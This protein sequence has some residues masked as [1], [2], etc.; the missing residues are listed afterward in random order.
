[1]TFKRFLFLVVIFA[2]SIKV[3]SQ[4]HLAVDLEHGVYKIIDSAE[5]KGIA[6]KVS[7]VRPFTR[8]QIRTILNEISAKRYQLTKHE[9][10]ILEFYIKE[11]KDAFD[12][13]ST[14]EQ[15]ANKGHYDFEGHQSTASIGLTTGFTSKTAVENPGDYYFSAPVEVYLKGDIYNSMFSY[16]L[17][18]AVSFDHLNKYPYSHPGEWNDV[19]MGFHQSPSD[20]MA[21]N[22]QD[23]M[24]I[25]YE[26][27][28]EFTGSFWDDRI[29]LR[30]GRIDD[31]NVGMG[32]SGLAVGKNATEYMAFEFSMRPVKSVNFYSMVASLS[33]DETDWHNE[34]NSPETSQDS[35]HNNKMMSYHVGEFF[36]SDYFYLNLWEEVIWGERFEFGYLNPFGVY[37]LTQNSEGDQD[38]MSMGIS[39][40][41]IAPKV[42]KVYY[43]LM[44]D[45][46]VFDMNSPRSQFANMAGVKINIP[47]LPFTTLN[48]QYTKIEPYVY[49]H[50]PQ[51]YEGNG[52]EKDGDTFWTDTGSTNQGKS[53]GSYLKPNSDEFILRL[54]SSPYPGLQTFIGWR[55]I[56][57]GSNPKVR[58]YTDSNGKTKVYDPANPPEDGGY[59]DQN[60]N[61]EFDNGDVYWGW[62][63]KKVNGELDAPLNYAYADDFT[64]DF[65]DDGIYD[66]TN[67]VGIGIAYDFRA[68][69]FGKERGQFVPLKISFEYQISYTFFDMNDINLTANMMAPDDVNDY[70][71]Y[72]KN[73]FTI[74]VT[75]FPEG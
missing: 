48:F 29:M 24:A 18:F 37:M 7:Q 64:K 67:T 15:S 9:R 53:I 25:G 38:N 50:Y 1:M 8:F 71:D 65:L 31:R 72:A 4:T 12:P 23:E 51:S 3:Y 59:Y 58:V 45:E 61:D 33:N 52:T 6:T 11:F 41:T 75:V 55:L 16:N 35:L 2:S 17:N 47:G 30:F 13:N 20:D 36:I 19:G 44:T 28:P 21:G 40:A 69:P 63:P 5:I 74:M 42:F 43:E 68:L 39:M 66:W 57:H 56:R 34:G 14:P 62:D 70:N 49:T 54:E 26:T 60:G 27:K 22:A 73:T 32:S 46:L 10:K